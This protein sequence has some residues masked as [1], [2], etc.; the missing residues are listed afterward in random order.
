MANFQQSS[1]FPTDFDT[2]SGVL[3]MPMDNARFASLWGGG[4]G[5]MPLNVVATSTAGAATTGIRVIERESSDGS[6][7]RVFRVQG[8]TP[9]DY[10]VCARMPAGNDY[11]RPLTVRVLPDR[12]DGPIMREAFQAS[13]ATLR[14]AQNRLGGLVS[15]FEFGAPQGGETAAPD[16][17]SVDEKAAFDI[18]QKW[19]KFGFEPYKVHDT[20]TRA[21]VLIAKNLALQVTDFMR[22]AEGVYGRAPIGDI[23]QGMECGQAF[24]D[25]GRNCRRDVVTH[26]FFHMVGVG[27]GESRGSPVPPY[28]DRAITTTPAL[29]LNSADHLAQMVCELNGGRTDACMRPAD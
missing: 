26:E 23:T 12:G 24:F 1:A 13:R 4:E 29:A 11:A 5:G 3:A 8:I 19:L 15:H 28:A 7:T 18:A 22:T 2:A 20:L 14:V 6:V 9:G 17:L 27:H 16:D 25:H 21:L 10:L